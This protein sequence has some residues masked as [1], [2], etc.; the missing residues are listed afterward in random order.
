[1]DPGVELGGSSAR[2]LASTCPDDR[3]PEVVGGA[4]R[5]P[6]MLVFFLAVVA[7]SIIKLSSPSFRMLLDDT[8]GVLVRQP[9]RMPV[10]AFLPTELAVVA[11]MLTAVLVVEM[12]GERSDGYRVL[13]WSKM[14][15]SISLPRFVLGLDSDGDGVC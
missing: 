7:W 5:I 14:N 1:M 3:L 10:P 8:L 12:L 11:G 2:K 6:K 15:G 13:S 4:G 9:F